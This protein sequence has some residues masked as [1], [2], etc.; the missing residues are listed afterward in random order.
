[1]SPF[2]SQSMHQI[3]HV[4]Y[5]LL[6]CAFQQLLMVV[7]IIWA[8]PGHNPPSGLENPLGHL[9]AFTSGRT[10]DSSKYFTIVRKSS[11]LFTIVAPLIPSKLAKGGYV[12]LLSQGCWLDSRMSFRTASLRIPM[13]SSALLDHGL[14]SSNA[15][16]VVPMS[17]Q[18]PGTFFHRPYLQILR[19]GPQFPLQTV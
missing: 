8:Q 14:P 13:Y 11:G 7:V 2:S 10:Q 1:M 15:R 5:F 17:L 16:R 3:H 12:T 9:I 6:Y 18:L 19:W 4:S